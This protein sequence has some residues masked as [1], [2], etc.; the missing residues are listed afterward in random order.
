MPQITEI[1]DQASESVPS[2]ADKRESQ[3]KGSEG[4][5]LPE[6]STDKLNEAQGHSVEITEG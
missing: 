2:V 6:N 1:R 5:G 3:R 4:R